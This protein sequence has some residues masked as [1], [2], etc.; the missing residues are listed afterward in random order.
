MVDL[1]AVKGGGGPPE[2]V[3]KRSR[4]VF[5]K[6]SRAISRNLAAMAA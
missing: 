6:G 5:W 2:D 3:S 1:D 4:S